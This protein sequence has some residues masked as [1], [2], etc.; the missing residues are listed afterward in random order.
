MRTCTQEL[1]IEEGESVLLGIERFCFR[2]SS[3]AVLLSWEAVG[4]LGVFSFLPVFSRCFFSFSAFCFLMQADVL[5]KFF[6]SE[7]LQNNFS[8]GT[9]HAAD[10]CPFFPQALQALA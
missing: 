4:C 7:N 2:L 10:I 1:C 3:E 6:V 8:L 5:C 9:V